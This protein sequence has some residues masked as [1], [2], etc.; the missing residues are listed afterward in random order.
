MDWMQELKA[1]KWKDM[2]KIIGINIAGNLLKYTGEEMAFTEFQLIM[3]FSVQ[4]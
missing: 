4:Y 2:R 1:W 3:S